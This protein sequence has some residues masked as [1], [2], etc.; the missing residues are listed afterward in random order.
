MAKKS[1]TTS[2]PDANISFEASIERLE[3]IVRDLEEGN[4]GLTESLEKYELG[5][6][7]LK[8]CYQMLD[9][10][11]KRVQLL[12]GVDNSGNA[13]TEDFDDEET[14]MEQS[15]PQTRRV[16]RKAVRKIRRPD[17]TGESGIEASSDA[18]D[19][20]SDDMDDGGTLF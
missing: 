20:E 11:E 18:D 19:F 1:K 17:T 13:T 3:L 6:R 7:H 2:A 16:K 12:T 9:S 15:A 14:A 4:L 10:A 8:R 5:V